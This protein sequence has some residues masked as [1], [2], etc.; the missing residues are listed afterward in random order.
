MSSAGRNQSRAL[1]STQGG[2]GPEAPEN[3]GPVLGGQGWEV[4]GLTKGRAWHRG[5]GVWG[6]GGSTRQ[7]RLLLAS[8]SHVLLGSSLTLLG[9]GFLQM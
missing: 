4:P 5:G 6:Q 8:L 1:G 3:A 2:S 9:F 7:P